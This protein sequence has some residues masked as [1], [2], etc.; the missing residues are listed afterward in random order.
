MEDAPQ[1]LQ[2]IAAQSINAQE[3]EALYERILDATMSIL[4]PDFACIQMFYPERGALR[5]LS[6]RGFS[7]EAVRRWKWVYPAMNTTCYEALRTGRRVAVE[8]VRSGDSIW[9]SDDLEKY[10]NAGIR[11]EQTTPLVSRSGALLGIVS[12]HWREPHKMSAIELRALDTLTRMAADL[13]ERSRTEQLLRESEER[14]RSSEIQLKN[15]QGFA[16]IGSWERNIEAGTSQWSDEMLRILGLQEAAD[17]SAFIDCVHPWDREKVLEREGNLYS[18][19]GPVE[20]EFRIIRPDGDVRFLRSI[21]ERMTDDQGVPV[22]IVVAAQ[23]ITD[24]VEGRELLRESEARLKNAERLAHAGHWSWSIKTNRVYWSEEV[25]RILQKP[26]DYMPAYPEVLQLIQQQDRDRVEQWVRDCLTEK[27]GRPIEA[28]VLRPDG[29]LRVLTCGS[30]LSFDER[31]APLA[32]FGIVQDITEVRRA[33]EESL[34]RQRLESLG[35]LASG[36]AHDFNNLL[37][38]VLAETELALEQCAVE[39][40]PEKELANIR[41]AALSGSEIARQ[42]MDYA[43]KENASI[44][45]VDLS[46]TTR[47]MLELLKVSV[48]KRAV[49]EA[50]LGQN[51]PAVR[52]N[53]GQIRQIVMN[54]VTNASDAIGDQGGTIG[55]TTR[56]VKAWARS[57]GQLPD[58][59]ADH[60]HLQLEISDTGRGMSPEIQA[61]AFDPFFTTKSA[62]HGL[63]L[64]VVDGIVRSLGGEIHVSSEVDKGSTFL[65]LLPSAETAA[66]EPAARTLARP[67]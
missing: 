58:H 62:G 6:H 11:G 61:R 31:G 17:F 48:S 52:A 49:L 15:A 27:R 42:L 25:Y 4:N 67:T 14:L 47:D 54:L 30:E 39:S 56:F 60:D 32:L 36:V 21:A 28:Q 53:G 10:L 12:T 18:T 44:E 8:D 24:Q 64:A 57:P 37:A 41:S 1:R 20:L 46:Q 22:R 5:L 59:L 38:G 55:V 29:E 19:L 3:A 66:G 13:I 63:G 40:F 7:D 26:R 51:L 16:R 65:I 23:D 35:A 50:D 2:Q 9:R 34:A 43:G 45:M 33:Q